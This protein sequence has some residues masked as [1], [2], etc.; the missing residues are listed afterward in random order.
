M[1]TEKISVRCCVDLGF[2][3]L[4][5]SGAKRPLFGHELREFSRILFFFVLIRE[6]RA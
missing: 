2:N 1:R 4:S 6:I 5:S 3:D